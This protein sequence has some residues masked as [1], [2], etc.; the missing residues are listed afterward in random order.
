MI[1]STQV[2]LLITLVC[3]KIKKECSKENEKGEIYLYKKCIFYK[4]FF[5]M[6]GTT[7]KNTHGMHQTWSMTY[8]SRMI[9]SSR[10]LIVQCL[11]ISVAMQRRRKK[12]L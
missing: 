6:T 1:V 9:Q 5:K 11:S 3:S 10:L 2:K 7:C 8:R 4:F 12:V